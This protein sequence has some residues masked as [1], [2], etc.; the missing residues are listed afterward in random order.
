M[1]FIRAIL[2]Y[3]FYMIYCKIKMY[4]IACFLYYDLLIK[5]VF[6]LYNNN[7]M[8]GGPDHSLTSVASY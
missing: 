4:I 2:T 6:I 8:A 7:T 5:R 3:F 1:L